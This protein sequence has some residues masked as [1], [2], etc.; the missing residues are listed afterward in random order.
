[1]LS[2]VA[3]LYSTLIYNLLTQRL[4]IPLVVYLILIKLFLNFVHVLM[5]NDKSPFLYLIRF[6]Q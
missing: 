4:D 2:H 3:R 6:R 5:E 1:M